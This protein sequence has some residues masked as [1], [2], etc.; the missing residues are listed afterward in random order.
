[1]DKCAELNRKGNEPSQI[2]QPHAQVPAR[3]CW[4]TGE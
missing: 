3:P 2:I 4:A 1:M